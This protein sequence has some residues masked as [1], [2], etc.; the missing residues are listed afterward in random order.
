MIDTS[1]R[2]VSARLQ[3][4]S[5][6]ARFLPTTASLTAAALLW[7]L[8]GRFLVKSPVLFVPFSSV[9]AR[10][11]ELWREGELQANILVSS[12]EFTGGFILAVVVGI[13]FGVLMASSRFAKYFFEPWVSMLYATPVLALGPLFILWLGIGVASKIAIVFLT[14]VFPILINTTIGLT[15]TDRTLIEVARA[16]GARQQQIFTKIRLPSATP[17]VIAGLRLG[18]ARALV[19]VVVAEL[20]GARAGLGFMILTSTQSFDTAAVYVGVLVLAVAGIASVE[21]L[22]WVEKRLVPWRYQEAE[23]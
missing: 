3:R 21:F 16:F 8:T 12:V 15:T 5:L 23:E 14:A 7:E 20:F 11:V 6:P 22:K 4:M 9:I 10:A 17:F 2:S 1:Y 19:G 18:V 13:A